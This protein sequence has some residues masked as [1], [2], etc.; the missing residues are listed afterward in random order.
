MVFF[1]INAILLPLVLLFLPKLLCMRI[2]IC[3]KF[4][5]MIIILLET[6][7]MS[8]YGRIFM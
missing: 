1:I 2:S 4:L 3:I 8:G 6:S 7:A 5:L